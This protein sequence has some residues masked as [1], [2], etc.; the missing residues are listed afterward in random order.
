MHLAQQLCCQ[1]THRHTLQKLCQLLQEDDALPA[2]TDKQKAA[3][4][5]L[6]AHLGLALGYL[7]VSVPS[8][9]EALHIRTEEDIEA[10]PNPDTDEQQL[11]SSD[12]L[13]LQVCLVYLTLLRP[14]RSISSA[15]LSAADQYSLKSQHKSVEL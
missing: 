1:Q 3:N 13:A 7:P 11:D 5:R 6:G 14:S 2:T 8:P 12:D 10:D 9:Q 15:D 4:L